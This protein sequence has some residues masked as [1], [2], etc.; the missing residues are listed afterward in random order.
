M[1][2]DWDLSALPTDLLEKRI[3]GAWRLFLLSLAVMSDSF[4]TPWTVACQASLSFI[5]SQ[6]MLKL[7]SIELVI[8]SNHLILCRPLLYKNSSTAR[9]AELPGG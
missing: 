9:L 1:I 7:M 4:V 6:G 5:I 3:E 8:S 2:R